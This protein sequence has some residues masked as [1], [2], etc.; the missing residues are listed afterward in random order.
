[1]IVS[2][3][4]H[5]WLTGVRSWV[6]VA[7][8]GGRTP[9]TKW[10]ALA[11]SERWA[12]GGIEVACTAAG[13]AAGLGPGRNSHS[14]KTEF[15]TTRMITIPRMPA[16]TYRYEFTAVAL[17]SRRQGEGALSGVDGNSAGLICWTRAGMVAA[18]TRGG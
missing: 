1:L 11:K 5:D 10:S 3:R 17:P 9:L 12:T 4:L 15:K 16:I 18:A 6:S 13:A 7:I 2:C 14:G 8:C